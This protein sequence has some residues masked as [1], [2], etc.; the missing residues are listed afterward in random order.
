MKAITLTQPW[1]TLW[2]L[3][4]KQVETRSWSTRYRGLL[5][6]HASREL[7]KYS[8]SEISEDLRKARASAMLERCIHFPLSAIVGVVDLVDVVPMTHEY[9]AGVGLIE[10]A[11]GN[12]DVGRRAWIAANPRALAEPIPVPGQRSVWNLPAEIE[13]QVRAQLREA[14]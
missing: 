7:D 12:F 9:L 8:W 13:T 10:R 6:I 11:L 2:A 4:I 1:A 5:A 3:G 14:A